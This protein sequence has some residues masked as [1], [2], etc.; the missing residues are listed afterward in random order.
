MAPILMEPKQKVGRP[1]RGERRVP[2]VVVRPFWYWGVKQPKDTELSVLEQ[3]RDHL[4][5]IGAARE[6]D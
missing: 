3:D 4:V 6:A 5:S 1:R 2:V